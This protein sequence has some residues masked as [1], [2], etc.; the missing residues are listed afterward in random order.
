MPNSQTGADI[1][2]AIA[3]REAAAKLAAE[4]V[5]LPPVTDDDADTRDTDSR[6]ARPSKKEH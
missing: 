2:R 6:P 5:A 4:T 1:R 3:Q